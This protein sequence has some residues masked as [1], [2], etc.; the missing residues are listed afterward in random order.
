MHTK[1]PWLLQKSTIYVMK[2]EY[3]W[4]ATTNRIIG[5][6]PED[7]EKEEANARLIAAAPDLL[8]AAEMVAIDLENA[9]GNRETMAACLRAAINKAKGE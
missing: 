5:G 9:V 8:E 1:G 6:M 4:V 7:R 2:P 3:E